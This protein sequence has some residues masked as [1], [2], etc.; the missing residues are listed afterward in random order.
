MTDVLPPATALWWDTTA[1]VAAV[2]N[3]LRLSDGD[4]DQARIESL[5][6]SA[7]GAIDAYLDGVV[8]IVGPPPP[9]WAQTALEM[10][11]VARYRDQSAG[12]P[13]DAF[14]AQRPRDALAGGE[15]VA[16]LLRPH[17]AR[18]GVA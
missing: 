16:S 17:R 1:T 4:V 18:Y 7:A 12:D 10:E 5:I 9:A 15:A 8:A 3:I 11:T 2:F 13:G 14:G 6:P